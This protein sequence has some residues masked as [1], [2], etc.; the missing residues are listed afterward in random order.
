MKVG[1]VVPGGF[2]RGDRIIPALH[3]LTSELA[4]RHEIHVFAAEG[5]SGPGRYARSGVDVHQLG[6]DSST[7]AAAGW[8]RRGL[9]MARY[10]WR[11]A[12]AV[13]AARASGPFDLFHAVWAGHTG[14]LATLMARRLSL[15]LIV[16][17][18]GGESVWL[19]D[20]RYG[21][22]GSPLGRAR[23]GVTLRLAAAITAGSAFATNFLPPRM[24]GQVRVIP[25]GIQTGPSGDPPVRPPGPP[26][27]L[28]QVADLNLVKDQ[29]TTLRAL[30]QVVRRLGD[31]SMDFIGEDTR[32][33]RLQRM[34][35]TLGVGDRVR[36]LGFVPHQQL[37]AHY[38]R[39][40]LHVISS[41]YESQGVSIL[42]AAVSG[43]PTVG[44]AVGLLPT[45]A[46]SA[47]RCVAPGDFTALA[48]AICE[49]LLDGAARDE[50]GRAARQW[51]TSHDARWTAAEF[52]QVYASVLSRHDG[53]RR[54]SFTSSGSLDPGAG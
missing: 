3:A 11:L 28:L 20:I 18:G 13:D 52:E 9:R 23:V 2:D 39:A 4:T 36:F 33:G 48:D 50:M 7:A 6:G 46:P 21:G 10:A 29:E 1:L 12:Q 42:E 8:D 5:E 31:V 25:L 19:P 45:L 35:D 32:G 47:A 15:P 17:I 43:I 27:R 37:T 14:L 34:A 54:T 53:I 30:R 16:S 40:H 38:A 44:T 51:A 24:T 49:T 22:A 41:R 26:W